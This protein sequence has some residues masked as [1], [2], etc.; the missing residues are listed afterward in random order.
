MRI[1]F[2][3]PPKDFWF[4]MG[5]YLPP[6]VGILAL[7]AYL[8]SKNDKL[9]IEVL[10]CQAERL[11]WDGMRGRIESFKPDVVCPSGLATCNAYA[12]V[13][14]V[15]IAKEVNPRIV[16]V[17]GGQHFTAIAEESL[18]SCPAID[19]VVMGEGEETL[20]ELVR[21]LSEGKPLT[22]VR[23]ISFRH[24]GRV[25]HNLD[26]PLIENLDDLPFPGYHFVAKNMKRY[27]FTMMAGPETGYALIEGARGCAHRCT[28]CSQWKHWGGSWRFKSAKRIADE[29]ERCYREYGSTFLWLT[30]DN[31]DLG[32]RAEELCD[33][34]TKRG[35]ADD[36]MWFV[37]ARCDDIV[38]H[39]EMVPKMR[40]AG[41]LWMLLGVERHDEETLGRFRK[42]SKPSDAR[43]A[44]DLL[45]K[46]DI[47]SQGMFIIGDRK[48]SR[49]SI[50]QLRR[51]AADIE[52]DLSIFTVLTPFP[53]TELYDIAKKNGWIEDTNWADYD[54]IHAIMPT[55]HLSRKEVQEELYE[56]YRQY[57]GSMR[58]RISGLF[59]PNLLKRRT[60]RYLAGQ[61]LLQNLRD[62]F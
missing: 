9:D 32:M 36:V 3:E 50:N 48:D 10:D 22:N 43:L 46:N 25:I 31:F 24:D 49:E 14:T 16:T 21:T 56:T 19:V 45:K 35:I 59:S 55:E 6:P 61:A 38:N 42:G 47:F 2:V 34:I 4:I 44:I 57:Y 11:D 27:H 28:F 12:V 26:R 23:G 40:K 1:L 53:G 18:Q 13:R 37:Q 39:R 51:F 60:Y 15:E 20:S 8:E 58:R 62:L 29:M 33:E 54:M 41:N 30:D 7:A 52:P 17:V 5:E